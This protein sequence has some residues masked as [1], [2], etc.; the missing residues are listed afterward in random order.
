MVKK[1]TKWTFL[2]PFLRTSEELH[3]LDISRQLRENHA[4]VRNYLNDF[5]KIGILEKRNK[6]RLTLYRL[7]KENP[8]I[9]DY[10]CLAEKDKLIRK[11]KDNNILKELVSLLHKETNKPTI[12]FGSA[13]EDLKKANDIDILT[14]GNLDE[15]ELEKIIRRKIHLVK[16]SSLNKVTDS[17]KNEILKKHLIINSSEEVLKWLV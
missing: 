14:T 8:L 1:V 4:T 15:E 9:I 6:G 11:T 16:I 13:V 10:L 3:L 7:I 12:I 2:E 17:L 5:E